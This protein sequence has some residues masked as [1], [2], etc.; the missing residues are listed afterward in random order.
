MTTIATV[1]AVLAMNGTTDK[2]KQG[3]HSDLR[4]TTRT[5]REA[6]PRLPRGAGDVTLVSGKLVLLTDRVFFN[7][8]RV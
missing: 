4:Q 5:N 6:G 3:T 2:A 8:T 1:V 7:Y